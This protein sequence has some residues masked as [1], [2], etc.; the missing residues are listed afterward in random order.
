MSWALIDPTTGS[1]YAA[2]PTGRNK[3]TDTLNT[4]P[5]I[6]KGPQA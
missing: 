1:V 5:V 3:Q 6:N 2:L 4:E